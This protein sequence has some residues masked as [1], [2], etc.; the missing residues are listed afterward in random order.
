M[1][2]T[3]FEAD[4]ELNYFYGFS[5]RFLAGSTSPIAYSGKLVNNETKLEL[6]LQ[7][8]IKP[9]NPLHAIAEERQT[10]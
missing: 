6:L 3:Q 10:V 1:R 7:I 4:V 8:N 5:M 9:G 2:S